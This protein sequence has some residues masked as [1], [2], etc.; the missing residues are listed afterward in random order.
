MN[1]APNSNSI[2]IVNREL[3]SGK[4]EGVNFG[5]RLWVIARSPSAVLVWVFGHSW[6]VNGHQS[7]AEPHLTLL[8]DRS[9]RFMYKPEYR[10]FRPFGRLHPDRAARYQNEILAAF[11]SGSFEPICE[12]II[13]RR[14]VIIDG[15][16]GSLLPLNCWGHAYDDW[17][18]MG[19][20]F[21]VRP[22]GMTEHE[23]MRHKLGWKPA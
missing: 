16:G 4:I 12:A 20:G 3:V 9:P 7:Y 22:E 23:T 8:P 1:G 19:G 6:S 10:S 15:G 13:K 18:L 17:R 14:T 11:G 21:I 5:P 2:A